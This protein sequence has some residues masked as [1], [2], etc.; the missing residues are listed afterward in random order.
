MAPWLAISLHKWPSAV[1]QVF[2]CVHNNIHHQKNTPNLAEVS[3]AFLISHWK[4]WCCG[5]ST[6]QGIVMMV[7]FYVLLL[8]KP[9]EKSS[10]RKISWNWTAAD[11]EHKHETT[12]TTAGIQCHSWLQIARKN[13]YNIYSNCIWEYR[14]IGRIYWNSLGMNML[15]VSVNATRQ[16]LLVLL[17]KCQQNLYITL[18]PLLFSL[19]CM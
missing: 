10:M 13:V 3:P 19:H 14:M 6:Y 8:T 7:S 18:D 16:L 4:V 12:W 17:N 5:P 2:C 11:R 1:S 9:Q 15:P